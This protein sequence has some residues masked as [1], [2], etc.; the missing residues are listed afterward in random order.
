MFDFAVEDCYI[1]AIAVS[2]G[3][4]AIFSSEDGIFTLKIMLS[5]RE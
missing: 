2:H 3:D 1:A 4:Q 5:F